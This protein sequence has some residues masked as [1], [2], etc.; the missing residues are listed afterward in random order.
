MEEKKCD[1]STILKILT[2]IYIFFYRDECFVISRINVSVHRDEK[3]YLS[4][5]VS[6]KPSGFCKHLFK[7][8]EKRISQK[9]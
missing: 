3:K 8:T 2:S 6:V 1:L 9:K 5:A 7:N 4:V